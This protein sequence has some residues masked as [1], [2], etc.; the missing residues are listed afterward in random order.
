MKISWKTKVFLY[1]LRYSVVVFCR[2]PYLFENWFYFFVSRFTE[3]SGIL[4]F[5]TGLKMNIRPKTSDRATITEM[6][7][8]RPYERKDLGY[9]IQPSDTVLDVGAN[10]G[11]F[12]LKAAYRNNLAI[13]Y[14]LEPVK[15]LYDQLCKNVRI[16]ECKNIHTYNL[17]MDAQDG[18]RKL[19]VSDS[20]SSFYFGDE[21]KGTQTVKTV[22]LS[23][24]LTTHQISQIDFLKMDC[25][26][27]EFDIIPNTSS[28]T[29]RC[30]NRIAM[31]FHNRSAEQTV[32][33]LKSDLESKG[34]EVDVCVGEWNGILLARNTNFQA[35]KF[36]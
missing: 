19:N 27:A 25:E 9:E 20:M 29:L 34:F 17:A 11:A 33:L 26:G 28:E 3:K 23:S 6:F 5:R 14:S 13:I 18:D 16:N 32:T 24:F 10:I 22:S 2:A 30:I 12:S 7:V 21:G 31:E 36:V 4:R 1:R 15:H 8:V 35:R